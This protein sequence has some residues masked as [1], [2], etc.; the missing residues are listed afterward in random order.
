MWAYL[1]LS[2]KGT[3][4]PRPHLSCKGRGQLFL[5]PLGMLALL[6]ELMCLIETEL[7]YF[8]GNCIVS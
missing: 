3:E 6:V 2:P 7:E 4:R 8:Q 5:L 1:P